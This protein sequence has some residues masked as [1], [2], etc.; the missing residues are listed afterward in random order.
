MGPKPRKKMIP[1]NP[2]STGLPSRGHF[3]PEASCDRKIYRMPAYNTWSGRASVAMRPN[4]LAPKSFATRCLP[5][6]SA[7][8]GSRPTET[9]KDTVICVTR[10]SGPGIKAMSTPGMGWRG[11]PRDNSLVHCIQ[12]G[13]LPCRPVQKPCWCPH[14]R[15]AFQRW[16]IAM[17]RIQYPKKLR[18]S[19][20]NYF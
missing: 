20:R 18:T 9:A 13:C 14:Y 3:F 7:F 4:R 17:R 16:P 19:R 11:R 12:Y 1:R 8:E 5:R 10:L 2:S 6:Q 15:A